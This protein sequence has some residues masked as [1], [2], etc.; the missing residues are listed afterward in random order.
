MNEASEGLSRE[1]E[2]AFSGAVAEKDEAS[3]LLVVLRDVAIASGLLSLAVVQK[4]KNRA[5]AN[6]Q[7]AKFVHT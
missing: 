1:M 3:L 4:N 7:V 2:E 5:H 6:L